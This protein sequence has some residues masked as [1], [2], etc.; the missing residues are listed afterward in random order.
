[1]LEGVSA[2]Q[3]IGMR[4][5]TRERNAT[6]GGWLALGVSAVLVVRIIAIGKPGVF[7]IL[8]PAILG[9]ALA[10]RWPRSRAALM[11]AIPLIA[12]TTVVSL[13][14]YVGLLYTPSLV[15]LTLAVSSRRP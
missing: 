7:V 15:L 5:M 4:S 12:A 8:A 13:I 6:I 2:R 3:P 14:G 10:V 9:G 1:M 11:S